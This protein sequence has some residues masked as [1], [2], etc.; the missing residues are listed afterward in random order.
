ML[1]SDILLDL[2]THLQRGLSISHGRQVL[3]NFL[4]THS[5]AQLALLFLVDQERQELQFLERRGFRP[6]PGLVGSESRQ[7]TSTEEKE[8]TL[9]AHGLFG[10]ALESPDML[11]LHDAWHMARCLPEEKNWLWE[12][13]SV[14]LYQIGQPE[15][16]QGVLVLCFGSEQEL[17]ASEIMTS[18]GR[19]NILI[20]NALLASYLPHKRIAEQEKAFTP[21][22]SVQI[23]EA[24]SKTEQIESRENEF[25]RAINQERGRIARDMHDG[26]LQKLTH[27]LHKL[28]L[29]QRI[30]RARPEIAL[31]EVENAYEILQESIQDLRQRIS[32][33]LPAYLEGR[34]FDAA[35]RAL[36]EEYEQSQPQLQI[37]YQFEDAELFPASLETPVFYLLQEALN[38]IRKHA[39]A[40]A[41]Q[42]QIQLQ[43]EALLVLISDNGKG[44]HLEE[45][46]TSTRFGLR[47]M[48]ER[49][50]LADGIWTAFSIPG[51]GTI[52]KARFPLR[53]PIF[54]LTRREREILNLLGEGYTN[55][56]IAELLSISVETVKSHVRHIIQ[57]MQVKD[58]TQA[59]VIASQQKRI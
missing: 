22:D 42:I 48:R 19:G 32:S 4:A 49:T 36:L 6:S 10:M 26:P 35:V 29:I 39:E 41:I 8:F 20:C 21:K 23:P 25:E 38:N 17:V 44:F 46:L 40:T 33:F 14:V 3:L 7:L 31:V 11:I 15:E 51:G 37:D 2:V 50:E 5:D 30:S 52:I 53:N 59:A 28:E 27:V 1:S 12:G 45:A 58:R 47:S 56:A 18:E 16:L 55:R 34:N 24:I 9:P 57:K 13:A 54:R 43:S